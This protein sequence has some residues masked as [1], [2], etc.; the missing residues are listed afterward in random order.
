[1]HLEYR[2]EFNLVQEFETL[3]TYLGLLLVLLMTSVQLH[4]IF[5]SL[6]FILLFFFNIPYGYY[7][8]QGSFIGILPIPR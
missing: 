3:Q 7:K 1:M 5:K 6:P 4:D 8:F 2:Y